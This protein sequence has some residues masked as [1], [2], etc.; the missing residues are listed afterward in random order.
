MAQHVLLVIT[1][2]EYGASETIIDMCIIIVMLCTSCQLHANRPAR[3]GVCIADII[4]IRAECTAWA[5]TSA[6]AVRQTFASKL[7]QV[8]HTRVTDAQT[9]PFGIWAIYKR[10][11]S[12]PSSC[13]NSTMWICSNAGKTIYEVVET[14]T[15]FSLPPLSAFAAKSKH[16]HVHM[17]AST[18]TAGV[19]LVRA[20]VFWR[21]MFNITH[22]KHTQWFT[23][24]DGVYHALLECVTCART[25]FAIVCYF[26]QLH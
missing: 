20:I 1:Q 12:L 14:I 7:G 19:S 15:R 22:I 5:D 9:H 21:I 4:T 13:T 10:P 6:S 8:P 17:C 18:Y 25:T 24:E 3:D 26:L 11:W 23:F 2:H 16:I